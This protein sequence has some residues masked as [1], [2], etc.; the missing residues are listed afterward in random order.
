MYSNSPRQFDQALD[1]AIDGF[2]NLYQ[3]LECADQAQEIWNHRTRMTLIPDMITILGVEQF[4]K[5]ATLF[6]GQSITFPDKNIIFETG[7]DLHIYRE[8]KKTQ[9]RK[10]TIQYLSV[11]H[12]LSEEKVVM[13][14]NEINSV[15]TNGRGQKTT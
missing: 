1:V 10:D 7:R 15:L 6:A 12:G 3:P 8:I 4:E 2:K 14:Y 13:I 9:D 11:K 5:I